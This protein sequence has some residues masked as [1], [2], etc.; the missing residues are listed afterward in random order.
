[1]KISRFTVYTYTVGNYTIHVC[2]KCGSQIPSCTHTCNSMHTHVPSCTCITCSRT[3]KCT[4]TKF[5]STV[6]VHLKVRLS[7]GI[8]IKVHKE[9]CWI[10][11]HT[12]QKSATERWEIHMCILKQQVLSLN[13]KGKLVDWLIGSSRLD[14][15]FLLLLLDSMQ[16]YRE[17][18]KE[19]SIVKI[20]I[21]TLV[22]YTN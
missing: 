17:K 3:T 21:T 9:T 8:Q 14:R 19:P 12:D 7:E 16:L 20:G 13:K 4:Q 22:N 18:V 15:P 2:T 6:H 10:Y 5:G 1:M 11:H